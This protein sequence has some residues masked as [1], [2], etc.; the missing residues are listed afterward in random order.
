MP[1]HRILAIF[2]ASLKYP[3]NALAFQRH[4]ALAEIRYLS[5]H[6]AKG[7]KAV[8]Q[9][10]ALDAPAVFVFVKLR[11]VQNAVDQLI[12]ARAKLETQYHVKVM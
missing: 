9:L 11:V 6:I 3:H 12:D 4:I 10:K 1:I 2:V 5:K 8:K 7:E